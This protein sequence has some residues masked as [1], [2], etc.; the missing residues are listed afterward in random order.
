MIL[1]YPSAAGGKEK[2]V[3]E[4][5]GGWGIRWCEEDE[6]CLGV[7][8]KVMVSCHQSQGWRKRGYSFQNGR[9]RTVSC[10]VVSKLEHGFNFAERQVILSKKYRIKLL[11]RSVSKALLRRQG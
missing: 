7:R 11:K 6:D 8:R 1:S 4:D 2:D 3:D 10:S 9:S 5:L